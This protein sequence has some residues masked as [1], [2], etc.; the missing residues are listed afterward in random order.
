MS[1]TGNID[2][3][4]LILLNLPDNTLSRVCSV[5]SYV[6]SIC[7]SNEFWV[8]KLRQRGYRNLA[9]YA[10]LGL[11]SRDLYKYLTSSIYAV[12]D[13]TGNI[14]TFNNINDAYRYFIRHLAQNSTT[15][16]IYMPLIRPNLS[17]FPPIERAQELIN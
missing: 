15:L 17:V 8:A 6:N 7:T 2:T 13:V 16:P 3:D 14:T 5:N 4:F 10:Y 9:Q 12:Y 1:L 11:T